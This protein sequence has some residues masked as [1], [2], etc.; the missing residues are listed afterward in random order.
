MGVRV[1]D[2]SIVG[3]QKT[4]GFGNRWRESGGDELLTE[5]GV[6]LAGCATLMHLVGVQEEKEAIV[7]VLPQPAGRI[8]DALFD[9][10]Q[11][12]TSHRQTVDRIPVELLPRRVVRWQLAVL[13]EAT[14]EYSARA[15][16]SIL[17]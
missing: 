16:Q 10:A 2:R 7:A 13:I 3:R 12:T 11:A 17:G 4:I 8:A 5:R 14:R 6:A 1:R 9:R 15:E